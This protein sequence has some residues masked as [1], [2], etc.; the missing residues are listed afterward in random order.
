MV[1]LIWEYKVLF[2][3]FLSPVCVLMCLGYTAL[4]ILVHMRFENV[5]THLSLINI[6][7]IIIN[8]DYRFISSRAWLHR[9]KLGRVC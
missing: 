4:R 2:Y 3:F 5:G 6:R 1:Q 7:L 8:Y 9:F